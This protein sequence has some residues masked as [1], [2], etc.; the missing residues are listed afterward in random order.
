MA[1]L[2]IEAP[3]AAAAFVLVD[4]LTSLGASTEGTARGGWV[5]V[6]PLDG[7]P[8]GTVPECLART[9]EWLD[10][11]SLASASVSVDGHTLL[12]RRNRVAAGVH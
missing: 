6:V 10:I 1:S 4:R 9:R 2:R 11:C 7:A 3:S 12:L 8:K 5:I